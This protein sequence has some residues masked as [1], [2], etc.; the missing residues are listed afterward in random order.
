MVQEDG[1]ITQCFQI[2]LPSWGGG[3]GMGGLGGT[4]KYLEAPEEEE[5]R[6]CFSEQTLRGL[7]PLPASPKEPQGHFLG[8]CLH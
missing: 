2:N 5:R 3:G 1:N 7:L 8:S 6:G 4:G